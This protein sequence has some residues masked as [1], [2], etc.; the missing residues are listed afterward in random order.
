M[1]QNVEPRQAGSAAGLL[2]T[3][4]QVGGALGVAV[5]GTLFFGAL[6]GGSYP[7]AFALSMVVLAA[8][9]GLTAA[10]VQLL[11]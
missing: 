7:H 9:T 5:I 11:P 8:L 1:L 6:P 4:Q 10:L 2:A 3:F